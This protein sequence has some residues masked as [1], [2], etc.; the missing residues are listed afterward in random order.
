MVSFLNLQLPLNGQGISE[1][2]L[3]LVYWW[4]MRNRENIF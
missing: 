1:G 3:L 4:F 2:W